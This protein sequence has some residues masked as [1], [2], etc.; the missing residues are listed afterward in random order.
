MLHEKE[1][2]FRVQGEEIPPNS[3]VRESRAAQFISTTL[4]SKSP[5]MIGAPYA[6]DGAGLSLMIREVKPEKRAVNR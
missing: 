6:V 5:G 1:E 4:R 2:L 3:V